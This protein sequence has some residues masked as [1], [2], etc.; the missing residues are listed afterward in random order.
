MFWEFP[1]RH[2]RRP[3]G[4]GRLALLAG[5]AVAGAIPDR[6]LT[7]GEVSPL[8]ELL[9]TLGVPLVVFTAPARPMAL[10]PWRSEIPLIT[11]PEQPAAL[12]S[13]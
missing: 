7:D 8:A 10:E 9:L 4:E 5:Q 3:G 11:K 13:G 1:K 6:N 12:I 2:G